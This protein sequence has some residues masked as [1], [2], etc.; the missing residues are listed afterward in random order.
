MIL[1][2]RAAGTVN[3]PRL[4]KVPGAAVTK[5]RVWQTLQ[6]T[7]LKSE[8]PRVAAAGIGFWRPGAR[9]AAMKSANASTS[10][11]SSSGSAT[12]S[13]GDGNVTLITASAVLH[14]FSCVQE[15]AASELLPPK[16][17]NLL[18]I[19]ISLR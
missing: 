15:S 4:I 13:K 14:G 1:L 18:V 16:P 2:P 6:P 11:P 3:A 10:P 12:G 7:A 19:P 9:V 5:V 17:S 8:S